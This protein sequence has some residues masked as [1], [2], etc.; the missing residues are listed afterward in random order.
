MNEFEK[1]VAEMRTAQKEYFRHRGTIALTTSKR[2]EK[3][4][5][6]H[7]DSLTNPKLF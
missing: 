5:D 7:L 4:V 3:Q 6:D 2:L 1:L